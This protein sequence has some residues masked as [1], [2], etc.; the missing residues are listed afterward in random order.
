MPIERGIGVPSWKIYS[1]CVPVIIERILEAAY[2][3]IV[4]VVSWDCHWDR[5]RLWFIW[6]LNCRF[7]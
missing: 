3:Y 4:Y 7:G 1:Y 6:L 2:I 5:C